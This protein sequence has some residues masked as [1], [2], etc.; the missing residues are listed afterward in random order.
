MSFT[1]RK[2]WII[3]AALTLNAHSLSSQTASSDPELMS[4][5]LAFKARI[6]T[7]VEEPLSKA[8]QELDQNYIQALDRAQQ[9]ATL[10]GKLEEAESLRAEKEAVAAAGNGEL[11]PLPPKLRELGALRKKYLDTKKTL[12]TAMQKKL[13]PLQKELTRQLEALAVKLVRSGKADAA[14]EARQLAKNYAENPSVFE[15]DWQ[16]QT[17]NLTPKPKNTPIVLKKREVIST[18]ESFKPPI[19][20]EMVAKIEGLDLRIGYAANQMIFNWEVRPNELRIDGGPADKI[21]T[22]KMGEFPMKKFAV[23]RWVVTEDRQTISVDGKQR[24]EHRG[25]YSSIDRPITILAHGSEVTVRS[26]KTRRL[27]SP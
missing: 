23:I 14:L 11:T 25:N 16:D 15:G 19:E 17:Q 27:P 2:I 3:A 26:I 1:F 22:P 6:A 5:L 7:D 24:F 20:I 4:L 8:Q 9:D 12:R 18:V 21:Y 10:K 13:E